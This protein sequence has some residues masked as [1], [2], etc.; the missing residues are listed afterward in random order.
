MKISRVIMLVSIFTCWS[1]FR[2]DGSLS[3][4]SSGES[5]V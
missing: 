1:T 2:N 5:V 3:L 4:K